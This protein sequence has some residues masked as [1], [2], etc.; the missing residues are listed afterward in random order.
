MT[1][2]FPPCF[3]SAQAPSAQAHFWRDR[4]PVPAVSA[5][6]QRCA[7]SCGHGQRLLTHG[8]GPHATKRMDQY[9]LSAGAA[10]HFLFLWAALNACV[11]VALLVRAL[12]GSGCALKRPGLNTLLTTFGA[13]AV[14]SQFAPGTQARFDNRTPAQNKTP[15]SR[16]QQKRPG[17]TVLFAA[18]YLCFGCCSCGVCNDLC[19]FSAAA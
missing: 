10:A 15:M 9:R 7:A 12:E 14:Q 17:A 11:R 1:H 5:L 13:L 2:L 19:C 4:T 6:T 18:R 3:C 8:A 16:K